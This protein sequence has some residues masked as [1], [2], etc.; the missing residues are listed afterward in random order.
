MVETQKSKPKTGKSSAR[1][2]WISFLF[3]PNRK[4]AHSHE[5]A[6]F[7]FVV[8]YI[9]K[10][11]YNW[12]YITLKSITTFNILLTNIIIVNITAITSILTPK[13]NNIIPTK[14]EICAN[15]SKNTS[16]STSPPLFSPFLLSQ[17]HGAKATPYDHKR[18]AINEISVTNLEKKYITKTHQIIII[19]ILYNKP[20]VPKKNPIIFLSFSKNIWEGIMNRRLGIR[21]NDIKKHESATRIIPINISSHSPII[22][23]HIPAIIG[24]SILIIIIGKKSVDKI[25]SKRFFL[26]KLYGFISI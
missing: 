22:A 21:T 9:F 12:T 16:F 14:Y 7:F 25:V 8:L 11:Q 5:W 15:K 1:K 6:F 10:T 18:W 20:S 2:W 3:T 19:D 4:K 24:P 13:N 26:F 17:I 23:N